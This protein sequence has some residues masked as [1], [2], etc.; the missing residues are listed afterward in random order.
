VVK[1]FEPN[2]TGAAP[3]FSAMGMVSCLGPDAMT[4]CAALRAGLVRLKRLELE[5]R[6]PVLNECLPVVG[7]CTFG[8]A[9]GWTGLGKISR[10]GLAALKDLLRSIG[11]VDWSR[12]GLYIALSSDFQL[13]EAAKVSAL[14]EPPDALEVTNEFLEYKKDKLRTQ[15]VPTMAKLGGFSVPGANQGLSFADTVG[16]IALLRHACEKL[17]R[18][19]LERVVIGAVDSLIEPDHVEACHRLGCLKSPSSSG[20][21][22]PGEMAA[23]LLLEKQADALKNGRLHWSVQG[24]AQSKE[25]FNRLSDDPPLGRALSTSII[26]TVRACGANAGSVGLLIGDLNG[27]PY[28]AADWG[29]AVVRLKAEFPW[30]DSQVLN[31][32]AGFGDAGSVNSAAA[33]CVALHGYQ[34]RWIKSDQVLVFASNDDGIRGSFCLRNNN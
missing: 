31:P 6:D 2:E 14:T 15:L 8:I 9:E 33:A 27:D 24:V 1:R 30:F 18:G 23:F 26:Q 21:L 5:L 3:G 34:R 17:E 32:A 7:H 11:R 16:F 20:G 25:P 4:S 29:N 10:L 19:E 22:I 28:R 13:A 12:T